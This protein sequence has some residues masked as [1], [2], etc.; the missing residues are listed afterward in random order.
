VNNASPE[1][2]SIKSKSIELSRVK[3]YDSLA[4]RY[5]R[6]L[7]YQV[8]KTIAGSALTRIEMRKI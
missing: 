3:L 4:K 6:Q 1:I 7:G 5:A 2:I 8:I